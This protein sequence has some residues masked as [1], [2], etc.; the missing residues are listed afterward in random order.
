MSKKKVTNKNDIIELRVKRFLAMVIDWYLTNMLAVIPIS[1]YFRNG[2]YLQ[3]YMFD[4]ILAGGGWCNLPVTI[5]NSQ[6]P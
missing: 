2:V 6:F 3:P 5:C 4:F 1:F